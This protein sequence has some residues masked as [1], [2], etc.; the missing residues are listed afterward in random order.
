MGFLNSYKRLDNLCRDMNG[1]G[2][3]GYIKDMECFARGTY[4]VPGWKEDY[5]QLKQYRHIRNR[6]A[7]ENDINENDLCSAEDSAWLETFYQRILT[8]NDPL[9]LYYKYK[10][11][12]QRTSNVTSPSEQQPSG[13]DLPTSKHKQIP[14]GCAT[15]ILSTIAI[16][17]GI[18]FYSL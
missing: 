8:Q 6:I 13:S 14:I 3:T 15:L 18:I 5:F 10:T 4:F 12:K 17:A 9:A 7:H 1:I 2:V 11:T 16:V